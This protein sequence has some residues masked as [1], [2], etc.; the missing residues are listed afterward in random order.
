MS[1]LE[2]LLAYDFDADEEFTVSILSKPGLD[3]DPTEKAR[4]LRTAKL[5]FFNKKTGS[6]VTLEE[7]TQADDMNQSVE[8]TLTFA[9]IKHLIETGQAHLIP[10]NK[11]IPDQLNDAQ[12]SVSQIQAKKKPWEMNSS[13]T[14]PSS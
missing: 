10:N 8:K 7:Y 2:Q 12:P 6:N 4:I 5:F 14:D 9:E 13:A 11:V 1:A 3:E